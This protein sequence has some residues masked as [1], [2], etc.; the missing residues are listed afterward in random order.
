M[1]VLTVLTLVVLCTVKVQCVQESPTCPRKESVPGVLTLNLGSEVILGCRGDVTVDG[2]SLVMGAKHK[3]RL[4]NRGDG[5]N[6]WRPQKARES[7]LNISKH[8]DPV[9]NTTTGNY[10]SNT[11]TETND[12]VGKFVTSDNSVMNIEK[13]QMGSRGISQAVNQSTKSTSGVGRV[14]EE[15]GA[16]SVIMEMG[17]STESNTGTE[18]EDDEEYKE[19]ME[20]LRVTRSSKRQAQWT[21]NGQL[22]RDGVERG[23]V[24]RLSA[25]R[26][27]DSGNYSCYRRGKLVSS[28]K[29]S[30]GTGNVTSSPYNYIPQNII[31]PDPPTRV[32][33]NPVIFEPHTLKYQ[34]V[35][36]EDT[37]L[38]WFISDA[39]PHVDYEVQIRTKDEYDG[40]WS[41]WTSPVYARTWAVKGN[42][43]T[44][45]SIRDGATAESSGVSAS[46]QKE[47]E[48][49]AQP[50]AQENTEA[51][52]SLEKPC[53]AEPVSGKPKLEKPNP[54][55]PSFADPDQD[56]PNGG[57]P[58]PSGAE[59]ELLALAEAGTGEQSQRL[60]TPG[61]K[62]VDGD[63]G[64]V[65]MVDEPMFKVPNK[66]KNAASRAFSPNQLFQGT[67]YPKFNS[68][69]YADALEMQG[70]HNSI[71]T[72]V[73][74]VLLIVSSQSVHA[75]DSKHQCETLHDAHVRCHLPS[76]ITE[77]LAEPT[78]NAQ[79]ISN[80]KPVANYNGTKWEFDH[81]VTIAT[82]ESV[83]LESFQGLLHFYISCAK[84]DQPDR[85]KPGCRLQAFEGGMADRGLERTDI[86]ALSPEQQDKLRQFKIKTRLANELYLRSHPEVE[87]MLSEFLRDVF[88]QR[89]TDIQ[90]FAAGRKL[91]LKCKIY[92]SNV[93]HIDF[94]F[95]F[96]LEASFS[97][98]N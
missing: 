10:N 66:R 43:K 54:E 14:T 15:G 88:V 2:I 19:K 33:V 85:F 7:F 69:Q 96:E 80:G 4:E 17:T 65:E 47:S 12:R 50:A 8:L 49:Q 30:V 37:E 41:D 74:A 20:G 98:I 90:K 81:P 23:G 22:M 26:L 34:Q 3:E 87:I 27:I 36:R 35:E 28:V 42:D 91:A 39:L 70:S 93:M 29:I 73:Q 48:L 25:L 77:E 53:S 55:K 60:D 76:Y 57:S 45:A 13:E 95:I 44:Q 92:H 32:T 51:T 64:D 97:V 16:F 78:C 58:V 89:P 84:T 63:E 86:G 82:K 79:W 59:L 18:Y 94:R 5:T 61:T 24:F 21:R 72:L 9:N 62:P 46:I 71:H 1:N 40:Q 6:Q 68:S 75:D 83:T 31:K 67:T 11:A 52:P 56:K 38:L